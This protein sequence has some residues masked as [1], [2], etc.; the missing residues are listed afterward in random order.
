LIDAFFGGDGHLALFD[1]EAAGVGFG[2]VEPQLDFSRLLRLFDGDVEVDD[3]GPRRAAGVEV[4]S[5]AEQQ[6]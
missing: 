2:E 1:D 5:R 4:E 3:V 6:D